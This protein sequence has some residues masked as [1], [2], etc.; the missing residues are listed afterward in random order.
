MEQLTFDFGYLAT[1]V[2]EPEPYIP[3]VGEGWYQVALYHYPTKES[4]NI[5]Q[6]EFVESSFYAKSL[7]SAKMNASK[8]AKEI[9][10]D[11][12]LRFP[13]DKTWEEVESSTYGN[14]GKYWKKTGKYFTNNPE[15]YLVP[16]KIV[17]ANDER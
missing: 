15:L 10:G 17:E 6:S 11:W 8:W 13:I 2:E 3:Q 16:N 9:R 5:G 7:V 1:P 12:G 14:H 4:L